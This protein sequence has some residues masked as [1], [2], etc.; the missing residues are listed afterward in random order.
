MVMKWTNGK[1]TKSFCSAP[2][3]ISRAIASKPSE[4]AHRNPKISRAS[5]IRFHPAEDRN[6]NL[7]AM[8]IRSD[9]ELA[10]GVQSHIFRPQT[11]QDATMRPDRFRV[12]AG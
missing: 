1:D 5:P 11:D 4:F 3:W 10:S 9:E 7:T 6:R 12:A 2:W 8:G